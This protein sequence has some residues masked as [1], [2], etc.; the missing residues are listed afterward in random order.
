MLRE[1]M[2]RLVDAAAGTRRSLEMAAIFRQ[3]AVMQSAGVLIT[4]AI[5]LVAAHLQDPRLR[6]AFSRSA[7]GLHAGKPLSASMQPHGDVFGATTLRLIEVGEK[8]GRLPVVLDR[9]ATFME[10]DVSL[11]L[12]VQSALT[13]PLFMFGGMLVFILLIPPLLL[14]GLFE[15]MRSVR[16]E[17]PPLTRCL[18]TL[19][20]A[21]GHPLTWVVGIGVLAG[22]VILYAAWARSEANRL[23]RDRFLLRVPIL[24]ATLRFVA[25]SSFC[26]SLDL[27]YASG[28]PILTGLRHAADTC[29]NLEVARGVDEVIARVN[30][31]AS[32]H[33]AF[34]DSRVVEPSFVNL[35]A[36]AE[37]RGD[38]SIALRQFS[39]LA[40]SEVEHRIDVAVAAL[41]PLMLLIMGCLAG[42]TAVAAL[43]PMLGFLERLTL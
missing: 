39:R 34:A 37:E 7:V 41:E 18:M 8:S 10:R 9:I 31:G 5:R 6:E 16:A 28:I 33:R 23:R 3:L 25:L 42:G 22:L 38:V 20:A 19:S 14:N 15:T 21:L 24:G 35:L 2:D 40:D 36:A 12:R 30:G 43:G 32:L 11:R 26:R 13:Y 1:W 4:E 27:M 29:G 17:V